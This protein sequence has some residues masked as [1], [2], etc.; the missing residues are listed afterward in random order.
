MRV[1][2]YIPHKYMQILCIA[3]ITQKN[4]YFRFDQLS[5]IYRVVNS[6][7]NERHASAR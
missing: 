6:S 2:I 1:V 4:N 5:I 3:K 7:V